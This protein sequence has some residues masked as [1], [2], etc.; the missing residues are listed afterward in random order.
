MSQLALFF[1]SE[2]R[3]QHTPICW[4]GAQHIPPA[5]LK[6][7]WNP[8]HF[9]VGTWWWLSLC[10]FFSSEYSLECVL[11]ILHLSGLVQLTSSWQSTLVQMI[12]ACRFAG[13]VLCSIVLQRLHLVHEL[14]MLHF[15]LLH[16]GGCARLRGCCPTRHHSCPYMYD[17]Y[18]HD[19]CSHGPCSR[20][21]C[22]H[23]LCS[24]GPMKFWPK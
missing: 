17:V 8:E 11:K 19:V 4:V 22:S 21:L 14:R 3:V 7:P 10:Y 20:G 16:L 5:A 15:W 12:V 24:R 1:S 2:S 6:A 9:A 13:N 23:G 18:M